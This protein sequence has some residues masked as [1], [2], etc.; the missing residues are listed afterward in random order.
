M[1]GSDPSHKVIDKRSEG[2]RLW[3]LGEK[4][5]SEMSLMKPLPNLEFR[6]NTH[7]VKKAVICRA[8]VRSLKNNKNCKLIVFLQYISRHLQYVKV[9]HTHGQ[10]PQGS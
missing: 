2:G 5:E 10:V 9:F 3:V 6:G 4:W 8:G 1:V 7:Q